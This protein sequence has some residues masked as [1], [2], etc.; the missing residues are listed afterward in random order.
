MQTITT[1]GPIVTSYSENIKNNVDEITSGEVKFINPFM[2]FESEET[3][4]QQ[5]VV[6]FSKGDFNLPES[7]IRDA[8]AAGWKELAMTRLEIQRKGEEVLDY[9]ETPDVAESCSQAVRT[10]W[11]RKSTTVSLSSSQAMASVC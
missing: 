8:V 6:T 11:T 7:Q 9:M 4:S 10:M 2:S 5:L 1:T 3:I